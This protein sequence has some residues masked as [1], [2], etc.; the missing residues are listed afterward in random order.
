MKENDENYT[1]DW[2][3]AMKAHPYIYGTRKS[4]LYLCEKLLTAT[5]Y[6]ESLLSKGDEFV[7][8]CCHMNKFTRR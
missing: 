3:I 2:L 5:A 6:L 8:K 7:L 1:I 4:D